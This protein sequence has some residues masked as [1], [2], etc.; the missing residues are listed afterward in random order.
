MASLLGRTA[1][2][3]LIQLSSMTTRVVSKRNFQK[4]FDGEHHAAFANNPNIKLSDD[5]SYIIAHHPDKMMQHPYE[6]TLPFPKHPVSEEE[7]SLLKLEV[8][9]RSYNMV[10]EAP[11]M[12][13]LQVLTY[14]PRHRWYQNRGK[15]LRKRFRDME[16]D[17]VDRPGL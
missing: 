2:C 7:L 14:T 16:N 15:D 5:E 8:I 10:H 9:N 12:E 17:T 6:N 13:Q 3:R 11:N 4:N 1:A